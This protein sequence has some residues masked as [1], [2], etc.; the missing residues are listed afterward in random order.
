[1]EKQAENEKT[2]LWLSWWRNHVAS[3][4]ATGTDFLI[5][6]FLTEAVR[7]WYLLSNTLGA[8]A[9]GVVSFLMCRWWVFNRRNDHW[10]RQAFRYL[11]AVILS[12]ILNTAGVWFFKEI[13]DV[14]YIVGKIIT[15][16]VIGVSVNF[17]MFRYFVFR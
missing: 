14:Q 2:P 4:T 12:I 11:I 8:T 13:L 6:I 3:V 5:T 16:T 1:M 15:A 9:G 7:L 17:L 10:H